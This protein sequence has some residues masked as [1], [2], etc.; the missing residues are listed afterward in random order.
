[1]VAMAAILDFWSEILSS[2]KRSISNEVLSQ[3]AF[4]PEKN[5]K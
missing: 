2:T 1:M 3:L 4:R 5:F